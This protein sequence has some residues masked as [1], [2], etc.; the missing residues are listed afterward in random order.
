M[1]IGKIRFNFR[2]PIVIVWE[3]EEVI[4]ALREGNSLLAVKIYKEATGKTLRESKDYV[5]DVLKPKYYI[6]P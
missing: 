5:R 3:N 1:K 6:E 2:S 4:K